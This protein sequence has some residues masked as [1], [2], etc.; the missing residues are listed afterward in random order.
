MSVDPSPSPPDSTPGVSPHRSWLA[1]APAWVVGIVL[2]ALLAFVVFRNFQH[3]N[4]PKA[5][6]SSDIIQ[7]QMTAVLETKTAFSEVY[8][9]KRLGAATI[10]PDKPVERTI[11]GEGPLRKA[12]NPSRDP[13]RIGSLAPRPGPRASSRPIRSTLGTARDRRSLGDQLADDAIQDWRS[14]ANSPD[15][16]A[17]IWRRL[18][19]ALFLFGRPGGMNAFRHIPHVAPKKP[20]A[21]QIPA[22]SRRARDRAAALETTTLPMA[23]EA[24]L[25]KAL[26]GPVGPSRG[27]VSVLRAKLTRLKLGWFEDIAAAQLY[28]RTGMAAEADQSS[29]QARKSA[30]AILTIVYLQGGLRIV[31]TFLLIGYV[32]VWMARR[33]AR[34]VQFVPAHDLNTA[35]RPIEDFYAPPPPPGSQSASPPA[36]A[37][38]PIERAA[39]FSFRTRL[40][41]FVVY[42]A[43]YLLIA[44][45]L[46]LLAPL[47][48][49][50]SDQDAL[51]LNMAVDLLAY[52][53]VTAVCLVVL[54]RL[55]E[56]EQQR[57]LSWRETWAAIGFRTD[58]LGKDAVTAVVAYA[59]TTPL[60]LL[61]SYFSDMLFRNFHTPIHPVDLIIVNTQD[62]VTRT[63]L[64]V[65]ACVGAPIVEEMTFRGMLFE[66]LRE[67]WG[68]AIAATLSAAVFALSHNTLPG[69]FLV[70]WTLGFVFALVYRRSRSLYVN[71]FMHAIHNGLI[72]VMMFTVFSK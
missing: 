10:T 4:R 27:D 70:L 63:L 50:L 36:A 19:I 8:A 9:H 53:P 34:T 61:A 16:G 66:G 71:I 65:Q 7:K 52:I 17:G 13:R 6:D 39:L 42:F 58:G 33:L 30:D 72:S 35:P 12:Q 23:E 45:P 38:P 46:Q 68:A 1:L 25:W 49:R 20:V 5:R 37:R 18:G 60:L 21:A 67:R 59:M 56:R 47:M 43:A 3:D 11:D 48:T 54:K 51:R 55:G 14:I 40:I 57:Q 44:W 2:L 22:L 26:Y 41:A 28:N 69:G 29:H 32:L 15:A 31:G 24:A 64:L 62:G